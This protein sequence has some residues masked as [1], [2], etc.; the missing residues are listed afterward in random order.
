MLKDT[1]QVYQFNNQNLCVCVLNF[2]S[3]PVSNTHRLT[4]YPVEHQ[5]YW[6]LIP[7]LTKVITGCINDPS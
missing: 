1:S 7:V 5:W 2:Q 3:N 6:Y 4:Q